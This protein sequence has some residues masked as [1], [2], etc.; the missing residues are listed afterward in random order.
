MPGA[1]DFAKRLGYDV[2]IDESYMA[3][4]WG[5]RKPQGSET[6]APLT[7][8]A[9]IMLE[10]GAKS[11]WPANGEPQPSPDQFYKIN[12]WLM[13]SGTERCSDAWH[14]VY[15]QSDYVR[16]SGEPDGITQ[17]ECL[18]DKHRRTG[19]RQW[20]VGEGFEEPVLDFPQ[21]FAKLMSGVKYR[22]PAFTFP[23]NKGL[24]ADPKA[25]TG[26]RNDSI[27]RAGTLRR[28]TATAVATM[29]LSNTTEMGID[30][31]KEKKLSGANWPRHTAP[32]ITGARWPTDEQAVIGDWAPR[33][34]EVTGAT[35]AKK[36]KE[37]VAKAKSMARNY[38]PHANRVDQIR[39]RVRWIR[40]ARFFIKKYGVVNLDMDTA[41]DDIIPAAPTCEEE[42]IFFG[43]IDEQVFLADFFSAREGEK[44]FVKEARRR[45]PAVRFVAAPH[46]A[47]RR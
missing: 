15:T 22:F 31:L 21:A 2:E 8:L 4:D 1:L 37:T 12:T 26:W 44:P 34:L 18:D 9:C 43:S 13:V 11:P 47:T 17:R 5:A 10:R 36:K 20:T 25:A 27:K 40:M 24:Y 39:V 32:T 7:P 3:V 19:V 29:T 41:W 23:E 6:R 33:T 14:S 35:H 28:T 46:K 38:A 42:K 30:E 45:E 16:Q